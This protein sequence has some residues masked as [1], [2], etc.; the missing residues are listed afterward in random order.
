MSM[1]MKHEGEIETSPA[2][3]RQLLAAQFP[4]W[5]ELPV[6]RLPVGGTDHTLYRIGEDLLARMPRIKWATDQADS[7]ERWLPLL[8]RH[9]PLA[10][11][12]PLA[13]GE[14]G[15]GFPWRWTVV[16]WLPG[17]NATPDTVDL[18]QAA[19]DLAAF[20]TALHGIDTTDR[21]ERTGVGRGAPLATRDELTRAAIAELGDRV[22]GPRVTAAWEE[23]VSAAAWDRPGV[24]IH[25]DLQPGNLLA[26]E[27]RLSAVI[28]FGALGVGD[29]AADLQPAWN[30]FDAAT[31]HRFRKALGYDDATWLRGMGWSLSTALIELPYY[32]DSFP[33][34]VAGAQ[35]EVAAILTEHG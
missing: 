14:P 20:V 2:L 12:A 18:D 19:D 13:V 15:E 23:A 5:A 17:G 24:W 3:V 31:R 26:N 35:Q 16:R 29:P 7:D 11:P 27:G 32:W 1:S 28:D 10:V 33:T 21:P 4:E 6:T 25:G 34:I 30:L 22:D 8:A 9:L